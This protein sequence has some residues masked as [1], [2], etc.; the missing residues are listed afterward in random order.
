MDTIERFRG[1]L[2]GL[3]TADAVGTAVEFFVRGSFAPIT[4]M[5][6][7]GPFS[8]KAGE[9]TDDTSMALCLATSLTEV[10]DF[11]PRDQMRRYLQWYRQGYLSSTGRCFD[12]GMT[13]R[14]AL[15]K[16]EATGNPYSGST[17]P[18]TA[19]NGS[20]M[21][22]APVA[23]FYFPHRSR[24]LHYC[25]ES[26]RTTHGAT[27]C[28]DAC[29]LLG[30]I[31]YRAL[32]GKDKEQVLLGTDPDLL[33]MASLQG[34]ARGEYCDK[35]ED[36]IAGTGYVV[37]S[38]EAALWSF[39]VTDSFPAAILK[40]VNLGDDADTTVAVCGQVAGA[41]YGEKGIPISWLERLVMCDKI[42]ELADKIYAKTRA[43]YR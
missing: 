33:T 1:C 38:L 41:F 7:G 6:G 36:D 26:S 10:G 14:G 20:I 37:N 28:I 42:R 8:L 32:A 13:V 31:L 40:A 18:M 23:M 29:G 34:I 5:I 16:Y 21:R 30:D 2:L 15:T 39:W 24:I 3:A 17:D 19:G 35:G 25:A 4:D 22:L 27:E 9:W 11:D 43:A 12:I